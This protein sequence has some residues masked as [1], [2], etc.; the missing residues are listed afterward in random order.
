MR[1]AA[2]ISCGLESNRML[3]DCLSKEKGPPPAP[4]GSNQCVAEVQKLQRDANA[5]RHWRSGWRPLC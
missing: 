5:I 1:R 3:G 2:S 4:G